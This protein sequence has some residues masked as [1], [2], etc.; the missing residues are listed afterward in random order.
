MSTPN[1]GTQMNVY[2]IKAALMYDKRTYR[3]IEILENQTLETLHLAIFDAFVLESQ[4]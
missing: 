2:C 4:P 1:R 3:N